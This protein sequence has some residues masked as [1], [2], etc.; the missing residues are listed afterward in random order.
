VFKINKS[1]SLLVISKYTE[2]ISWLKQV[3]TPF[4]IYDK[5]ISDT[6][7]TFVKNTIPIS[8]IGKE[9]YV[10]L[11]FI[12]DNYNSLPRRVIF[13][14]ADPFVHSPDFLNLIKLEHKFAD[15]Q[16]LSY[17]YNEFLPG[18]Q[19]QYYSKNLFIDKN[20][21]HVD[22]FDKNLKRYYP[23][24]K[25]TFH[26][27]GGSDF[28]Q[29]IV[30][31]STW[32]KFLQNNDEDIRSSMHKLI[33]IP[34]RQHNGMDITPMCYAAIFST[35]RDKILLRPK[36]YY[37]NLINISTNMHFNIEPKAFGWIMEYMWLE[38][39]EYSSNIFF[40]TS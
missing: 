21:I 10:Y 29:S 22:F 18:K 32:Y 35:T 9:E 1:K 31:C 28:S 4:V 34:T 20:R 3:N 38:L 7:N 27:P 40:S 11:K 2:N 30:P 14:Q 8:N 23:P 19:I 15:T 6:N 16:P 37:E 24:A 25:K 33:D 12:V 17:Q 26:F 39:F 5:N 36:S 13:S